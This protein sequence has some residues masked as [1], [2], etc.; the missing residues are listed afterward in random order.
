MFFA[1]LRLIGS[2][3]DLILLVLNGIVRLCTYQEKEVV[4]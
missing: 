3:E 1:R 2:Y 4:L